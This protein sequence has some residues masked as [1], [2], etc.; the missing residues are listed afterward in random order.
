MT[1]RGHISCALLLDDEAGIIEH[2]A[3]DLFGYLGEK[4][5]SDDNDVATVHVSYLELYMEE[6][7]DLLDLPTNQKGLA[8]R[9][10]MNGNTGRLSSRHR[11]IGDV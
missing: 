6:V 9:D 5:K 3:R 1:G 8:V 4:L 11:T 10:D 2:V 7:R